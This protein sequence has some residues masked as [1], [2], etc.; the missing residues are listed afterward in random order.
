MKNIKQELETLKT[1]IT[2]N[3]V[4]Q[5]PDEDIEKF[6]LGP[7]KRIR[8]IL[9]ILYIKSYGIDIPQ[10]VF[11]ILA[12]GEIIHNA[13]LLHDDVIDSAQTRRNST[14]I[15]NKYSDKISI[16]SGDYLVSL[17]IEK[18]TNTDIET[19]RAFNECTKKMAE[20]EIKQFFLR[21]KIPT[22]YE[23]IEICENK[24]AYLFATILK[25]SAKICGLNYSQAEVF[26]KLFGTHFQIIN[27]LELDSALIDIENKIYTANKVLGIE[28]TKLLLDNYRKEMRA[29]LGELPNNIYKTSLEELIE[30]YDR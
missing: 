21:G 6:L 11:N 1:F 5:L 25:T 8:S 12:A 2:Q 15:A 28:K 26:G 22:E 3:F 18:L 9:T 19:I 14:T 4:E 24:T 16:L 27:D 20:A 30:K 29:I 23:Y 17:A 13:S 10:K 7:S